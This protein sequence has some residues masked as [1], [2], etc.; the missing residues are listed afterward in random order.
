MGAPVAPGPIGRGLPAPTGCA[1]SPSP[2]RVGGW[3]GILV[4]FLGFLLQPAA[5]VTSITLARK[6]F[7][8]LVHFMVNG[9]SAFILFR[10]TGLRPASRN[11][12]GILDSFSWH[13]KQRQYTF[14]AYSTGEHHCAG[15][16]CPGGVFTSYKEIRISTARRDCADIKTA[17]TLRG[18]H[19]RFSIRRPVRLTGTWHTTDVQAAHRTAATRN[20]EQTT[21][22][23]NFR[24]EA[25]F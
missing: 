1:R 8:T 13:V 24:R 19:D 9:G 25:N 3:P 22:L 2:T 17:A 18:K 7:K 23:I 6:R 15:I 20:K 5:M 12:S 16:G 4:M 11:L 14:T 21:A 10:P